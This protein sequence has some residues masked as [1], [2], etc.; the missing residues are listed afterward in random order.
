LDREILI[1]D[2]SFQTAEPPPAFIGDIENASVVV[3]F[4]N[5]GWNPKT[6]NEFLQPRNS[7]AEYVAR[8][9]N[10]LACDPSII[11]PYYASSNLARFL[12]RGQVAI[13]N[14]IPYRSPELSKEP[15]NQKFAWKLQSSQLAFRWVN[16]VA[17]PQAEA[18]TR[19]VVLKRKLWLKFVEQRWHRYLI[20]REPYRGPHVS[21]ET[22]HEIDNF[23]K[24]SK[25]IGSEQN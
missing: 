24:E 21:D 6:N 17:M 10:S 9:H 25:G 11:S 18:H 22:R 5:G 7:P 23:I 13:L 1:S 20:N 14:L 15:K 16:E 12:E 3:L 2:N 4:S 19:L 8:L